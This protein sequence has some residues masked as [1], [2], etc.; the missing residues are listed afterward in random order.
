M[1]KIGN[2][3]LTLYWA[4]KQG[5]GTVI[6]LVDRRNRDAFETQLEEMYRQRHRVYV[7]KRGWKA[8][9]RPDGREIDQFDNAEAVY[10]MK[11][12][13]NGSVE[14][15][16]R[17]IPTNK[18]HLMRDVFA[19]VVTSG[20]IPNDEKIY[21]MTRCY[22]SEAVTDKRERTMAAGELLAAQLEYGL[23]KGLTD[24][25]VVSDMYFLPI[26]LALGDGVNKLG[27]PYEYGEGTCMALTFP[28]NEIGLKMCRR[29]RGLSGPVLVYSP[30]P[31]P[32]AIFENDKIAA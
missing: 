10:L 9:A 27:E 18:P 11:L 4:H 26:M 30:T 5:A 25:S 12:A 29:G 28:I 21:E 14:G 23:A 13:E 8:L 31:P 16:V 24:Y 2:I 19:H 15:A 3:L 1:D 6:Y 22:V 20:A 7:D 17:L 32:G